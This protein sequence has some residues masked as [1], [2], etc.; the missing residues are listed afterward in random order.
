MLVI[1]YVCTYVCMYVCM[2]V[3]V[4][5]CMY[6]H[7]HIRIGSPLHPVQHDAGA[8]ARN[9]SHL[10]SDS[11]E[12][13]HGRPDSLCLHRV[14]V[15]HD[16]LRHCVHC[17]YFHTHRHMHGR[18]SASARK[19]TFTHMYEFERVRTHAYTHRLFVLLESDGRVAVQDPGDFHSCLPADRRRLRL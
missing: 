15:K 2:Y 10:P 17:W 19:H 14:C 4:C 12:R 6:T 5:V 11:H 18:A 9:S 3:C 8:L 7:T 1:M 16:L 13:Q